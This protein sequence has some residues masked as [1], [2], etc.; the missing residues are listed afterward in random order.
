MRVHRMGRFAEPDVNMGDQTFAFPGVFEDA[1]PVTKLT[2]GGRNKAGFHVLKHEVVETV[3]DV[4]ELDPIRTDVLNGRSTR[5]AGDERK[6]FDAAQV[7]VEAPQD[8]PVPVFPRANAD[9][10]PVFIFFCDLDPGQTSDDHLGID[11]TAEQYI[12]AS[13]DDERIMEPAENVFYAVRMIE[14]E[15]L[16]GGGM[17][18]KGVVR[19]Q[20]S[21]SFYLHRMIL[22]FTFQLEAG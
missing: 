13:A 3:E 22:L 9:E 1:V 4:P 10:N 14:D 11:G 17:E 15:K 18:A 7:L 8:K 2:I 21:V 12:A 5:R 6:I 16:T 20:G 19:L